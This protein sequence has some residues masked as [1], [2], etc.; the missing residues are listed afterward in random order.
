MDIMTGIAQKLQSLV[1]EYGLNVVGALLI[2]VVGR[3]VARL[4]RELLRKLM[5]Q[6]K[7]DDTLT[8]FVCSLT[9]VGLLAFVIIAAL[10]RL[11]IQTASFI[12]VIG[13][14][15]LAVG[16]AL[17]G[18][19]ANFAAGVLML[20]FKPFK[21]GDFIDAAGV[22]GIVE[23]IEIFTTQLRTPDNKT[24]IVPN[25]RLTGDNITNF[26]AK[27]TRRIDL[28]V[29]VSYGD[30]LEKVRRS[31]E[32]ILK[33]DDRILDD[34]A[35]TIGVVELADSSVNLV[36]RPWVKTAAYWDVY[37]DTQKKIKQRFDAEGIS[38]PFP[39]RDVHLYRHEG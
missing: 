6:S 2:L 4:L 28:V 27:D 12:A 9:Y 32:T 14:A 25:A 34:P 10:A 1:A 35:P 26:S 38:I 19:L 8:G 30:D 15:G 36:V 5:R 7:V 22:A 37:F 24:I 17:Q 3:W 11:G 18:S 23:K 21:V 16:L 13:A 39:Q 29:G 20:V 31:L 33:E